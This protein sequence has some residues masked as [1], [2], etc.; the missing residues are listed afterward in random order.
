VEQGWLEALGAD[1]GRI[2]PEDKRPQPELPALYSS[3]QEEIE[4]RFHLLYLHPFDTAARFD[5]RLQ[6][7][8]GWLRLTRSLK[9]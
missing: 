4:R 5:T 6:I 8:E 1:V 9:L 3:V 2:V 7:R